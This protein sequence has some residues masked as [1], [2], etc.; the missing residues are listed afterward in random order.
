MSMV[1]LLTI[2]SVIILAL[3]SPIFILGLVVHVIILVVLGLLGCERGC[4]YSRLVEHKGITW[5]IFLLG[6]LVLFLGYG[7]IIFY[8]CYT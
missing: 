1:S 3:T 6:F 7:T 2:P 4:F 5:V 8:N